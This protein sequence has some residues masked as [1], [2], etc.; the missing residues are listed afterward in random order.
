MHRHAEFMPASASWWHATCSGIMIKSPIP[1][2]AHE[3]KWLVENGA[4]LPFQGASFNRQA[5]LKPLTFFECTLL[6]RCHEFEALHL[7]S[8]DKP[9][10][11]NCTR[12]RINS[13]TQSNIEDALI[14]WLQVFG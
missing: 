6:N 14:L 8:N 7:A 12:R 11:C 4:L 13:R 5:L 3:N 9:S 10:N 2:Q 1:H